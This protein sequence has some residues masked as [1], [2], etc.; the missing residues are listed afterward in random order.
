MPD[1]YQHVLP[2]AVAA[3]RAAS[4]L[5]AKDIQFH[6]SIDHKT[7]LRFAASGQRL[8]DLANRL[9][10][11]D[12]TAPADAPTLPFGE[13]P[14][15]SDGLWKQVSDA[16]DVLFDR[17][18]QAMDAT[19]QPP[20]GPHGM[21]LDDAAPVPLSAAVAEKPQVHFGEPV[22]NSDAHPFVPRL[23]A[24][25]HA[26]RP[27]A[28]CLVLQAPAD[29]PA[30]YAQPYAEE[31][32]QSAYPA[33]VQQHAEVQAPVDWASSAATWVATPA[34]LAAMVAQ[35]KRAQNIAVDVEH[36][37]LRSYYGLTCLMQIS[38]RHHDWLVD[39]LALR[40]ALQPLNDVFADPRI[41]K[42]FHGA[43]MDIVWL[44]RDL[45][46]YVV[47]LFDTYH[48]ARAL[49]LPRLSLAYL[50]ETLAHFHTLK[51]YQLADWR[52][53]PLPPQMV[54]Y[55]RADTHF[56]LSIY[57]QLR[58]RLVAAG[59]VHDVL[60]HSRR[61]AAR[62]FEYVRFRP[63]GYNAGLFHHDAASP[64][65]FSALHNIP[66]SRLA[67][68]R[69]LFAWRDALARALDESPRY[70]MPARV[71]VALCSLDPPV[72]PRLVAACFAGSGKILRDNADLLTLLVQAGY[73][74]M[75]RTAD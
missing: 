42:V 66:A 65:A 23:A 38:D 73:A 75:A 43:N 35:L 57:D 44:Q 48:A 50:L 3:V 67:L 12:A 69:S 21:R 53:R 30:Q 8:L 25:P 15:A 24:K 52:V 45:G 51:K 10:A 41:V 19:K 40:D 4:A 60:D 62:R 34:A 31:I 56:L 63:P 54:D 36:H 16:L 22:D 47:S 2:H 59:R 61:V 1:P 17:A 9:L 70:V 64:D 18:D 33:H 29:A 37:D 32:A 74:D 20:G 5:A 72:A 58:N 68:V 26:M 6:R 27:L 14:A 49:G 55:A 71:L 13:T 7:G 28:E 39:T 11:P 46:L